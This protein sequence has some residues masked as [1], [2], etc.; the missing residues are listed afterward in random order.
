MRL[1]LM[2][3]TWLC[4]A[5]WMAGVYANV[6][7]I[8]SC[9][10][11]LSQTRVHPNNVV[12]YTVQT[13]VLCSIDAIVSVHYNNISYT[14]ILH[15]KD[16]KLHTIGRKRICADPGRDWVRKAVGKVDEARMIKREEE[17]GKERETVTKG[18]A[19]PRKHGKGQK[20]GGKKGKG[21]G[22]KRGGKRKAVCVCVCDRGLIMTLKL[23]V[24]V[25]DR[26]LIMT[27]K[28]YVF[29]CDGELIMTLK[30]YVFVCVWF[31]LYQ[32]S[33]QG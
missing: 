14:V 17:E 29:V 11:Q 5:S 7:P 18:P 10:L 33:S 13:T 25:C 16:Y 4:V 24:F 21:K 9:C 30:L 20:K 26:R 22:G 8:K 3:C 32:K 23:Y 1:S 12:D 15:R 27:L 31:W 28:L 2:F 19:V 6:G